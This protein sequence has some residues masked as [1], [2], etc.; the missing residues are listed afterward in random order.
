MKTQVKALLLIAFVVLSPIAALAD[1]GKVSICR[2]DKPA[3][4]TNAPITATE[5]RKRNANT[6]YVCKLEKKH[7]GN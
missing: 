1:M 5:A 4:T 6:R 2:L 3:P 7:K